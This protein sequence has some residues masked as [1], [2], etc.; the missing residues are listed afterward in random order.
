MTTHVLYT[1]IEEHCDINRAFSRK[2]LSCEPKHFSHSVAY[3]RKSPY[4]T[5]NSTAMVTASP[6][7]PI[8]FRQSG[9]E[10]PWPQVAWSSLGPQFLPP[11]AFRRSGPKSR[12]KA[13]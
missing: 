12:A 5:I 11:C 4:V 13:Q 10:K 8:A 2:R 1:I 6:D 7:F 3:V 9:E